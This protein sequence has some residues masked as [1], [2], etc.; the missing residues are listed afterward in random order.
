M[1]ATTPAAQR[2]SPRPLTEGERWTAEVLA[3]LRRCGY[4]PAAWRR[5][6]AASFDRAFASRRERPGMARQARRW[7]GL[8]AGAWVGACAATR[9]S[10]EVHARPAA[11]LLWWL[12]VWQ[13]LEWHLG[14]AEGGDG[15]PRERL[16]PADGV[17]LFR[18]WLVPAI[19]ALRRSPGGLPAVIALGGL[20]D[21]LDGALA[22]RSGRTRLGRDLDTTADL[23]FV[24]TVATSARAEARLS[25][26]AFSALAARH[27]A[28]VALASGAVLGRARRP[29]I[30][31]RPW[32]AV[33][34]FGGLAVSAAG[35]RGA[36]TAL[37]VAGCAVP[38]RSTAAHLSRA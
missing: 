1:T 22:R 27:L 25:P 20:T 5:F 21:G 26:L 36:G 23:A 32:G 6:V 38:P 15:R 10:D 16:S 37:V 4:R 33:L 11:G 13:M 12:A 14:M 29:A 17:T 19:P 3:D 34:R 30:R 9:R 31:A 28:G 35:A 2:Y 7:A 8:G 18:F 24:T